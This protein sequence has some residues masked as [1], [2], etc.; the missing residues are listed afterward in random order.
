MNTNK[1][2]V[3]GTRYRHYKNQKTYLVLHTA[4]HTET[5]EQMVVYQG[6]Y[7]DPELGKD[8]IFVRPLNMFIEDVGVEGKKIPR[9]TAL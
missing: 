4:L 8:P 7:E 6:E 1:N 3:V 9:F 5:M 2:V